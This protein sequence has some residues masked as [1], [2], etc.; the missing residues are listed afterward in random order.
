MNQPKTICAQ[1]SNNCPSKKNCQRFTTARNGES[2]EAAL[3][4]RR[5]AGSTACDMYEPVKVLTTFKDSTGSAA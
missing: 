5:E 4:V 3:Y 2:I 1:R